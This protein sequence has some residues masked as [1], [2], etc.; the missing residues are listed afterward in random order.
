MYKILK[1]IK[2]PAYAKHLL[3]SLFLKMNFSKKE[4]TH[5]KEYRSDSENGLYA[6]SIL[7]AVS[8]QKI[9]ENFKRN[10]SYQTILEHVS[11]DQGFQYLNILKSRKDGILEQAL[12]TVLVSD[13]IGNPIKY[14]YDGFSNLLSPTTLRYLKVTSDLKKMFG[15][16]L[17]DVVEIGCGYGGQALVN[18]QLLKVHL[19]KLFDLPTVNKL[20]ERYLNT[21][22]MNGGYATTVINQ[23]VTSKYNLAISNYAFSELPKKLQITYID[24]VLSQ[25]NKG[26]LTMNSGLP[27]SRSVGKLSLEELRELLP[28]FEVFEEEPLTSPHNY[29]IAWGYEKNTVS[30]YFIPKK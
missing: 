10:K 29:I 27:E 7:K 4:F 5:S 3:M 17:G 20:I 28:E 2:R 8:K 1:A 25:S 21:H 23:E 24:K 14:R 15:E 26:Y 9:F 19:A 11:Q 13:K 12:G 18:D 6:A 30:D 16:D 22:L